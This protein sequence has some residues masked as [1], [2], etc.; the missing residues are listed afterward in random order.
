[1]APAPT[2][3]T[4]TIRQ[5]SDNLWRWS[6]VE[7]RW[8]KEAGSGYARSK[9]AARDAAHRYAS[10]IWPDTPVVEQAES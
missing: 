3:L 2:H 9:N 8:G 1:M 7:T 4:L 5:H 10:V 6:L